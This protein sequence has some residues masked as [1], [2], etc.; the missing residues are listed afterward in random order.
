MT[1]P[2]LT[3]SEGL[4]TASFL[5]NVI[6]LAGAWIISKQKANHT[7]IKDLRN[8]HEGRLD[9]HGQRLERLEAK[10][11]AMPEAREF[12]QLAIEMKELEGSINSLGA[13]VA[14]MENIS[15]IMKNQLDQIDTYLRTSNDR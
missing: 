14:G 6:L 13:T 8:A 10:L 1:L 2:E 15:K 9:L 5:L 11:E 4:S 12:T 7:E 3:L